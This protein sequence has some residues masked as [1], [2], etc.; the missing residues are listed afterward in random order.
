M[1]T[2]FST[3]RG[4]TALSERNAIAIEIAVG[5]A[6]N[7]SGRVGSVSRRIN[8]SRPSRDVNITPWSPVWKSV[9]MNFGKVNNFLIG[10]RKSNIPKVYY[11]MLQCKSVCH[12]HD[13]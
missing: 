3:A 8:A 7:V 11:L 12:D 2:A 13:R 10:K 5:V 1:I 9:S 4:L 6:E